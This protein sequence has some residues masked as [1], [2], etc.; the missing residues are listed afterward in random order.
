MQLQHLA[1][2]VWLYPYDHV[3]G[4]CMWPDAEVLGHESGRRL[5]EREAAR[6]WSDAHLRDAVLENPRLGP[7]Y[8]ARWRAMPSWEGFR[9]RPPD[10][11]F[12]DVL[13]L[14]GGIEVRHVGGRH[15]EDS[16]VVAV[17][18]SG[19]LLLGD[20]FYPPPLHLR[21]VT[22]GLDLAMLRSLVDDRFEWYVGSHDEPRRLEEVVALLG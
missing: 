9:V 20:C 12:D 2:Q 16:A 19:V 15:A 21:E 22:D 18:D 1:G 3:W 6:P 5:L 13:R 10:R 4:A 14:P 7:S 8:D 17:P 11:T